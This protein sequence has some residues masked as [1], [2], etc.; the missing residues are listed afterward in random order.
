MCSF[1][2]QVTFIILYWLVTAI[3]RSRYGILMQENN[4]DEGLAFK[5]RLRGWLHG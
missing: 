2:I 1:D 3:Y 5:V 4:V